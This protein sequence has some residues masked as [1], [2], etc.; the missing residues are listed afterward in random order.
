MASG[1][2]KFEW[3]ISKGICYSTDTL[4]FT[5]NFITADAG[6]DQTTCEDF[7]NLTANDPSPGTGTWSVVASSGNPVF[8][9]ITGFNTS[10]TNL[11]IN[12][13]SLQWTVQKGN[14]SDYANVIIT[15]NK[16]TIAN[17]GADKIICESYTAMAGNNPTNGTGTW[18]VISGNG[19]FTDA[20]AYNTN[21]TSVNV[22][23]NTY[24]WKI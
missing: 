10:V 20:N 5:N 21:I 24:E 22:G 23:L 16:P 7:A 18:T 2:N 12:T 11:G 3:K 15:S 8:G 19:V 9:N 17:A 6:T 1:I 4:T 14:C 13:N